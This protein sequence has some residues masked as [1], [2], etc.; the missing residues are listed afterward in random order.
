VQAVK[1]KLAGGRHRYEYFAPGANHLH[2]V[3]VPQLENRAHEIS[4]E[5]DVPPQ[6][7]DGALLA[8]GGSNGGFAL[9]IQDGQPVFEYNY[10][11]AQRY[12]IESTEPLPAGQVRVAFK[13]TPTAAYQGRGTLLVNGAKVAE[14]EIPN[15]AR[16]ALF[17]T[18]SETFDIGM[19]AGTAVSDRYAAPFPFEGTIVKVSLTLDQP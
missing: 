12:R 18:G 16:G 9:F 19:D 4:A 7:A 17:S 6:G 2:E 8:V 14:G 1:A 5:I 11:S 15:M 10:F 13:F 3:F